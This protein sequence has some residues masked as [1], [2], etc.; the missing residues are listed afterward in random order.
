MSGKSDTFD[1]EHA[2]RQVLSGMTM[3]Q[4]NTA[5]SGIEALRLIE[6]ARDTAVKSRATTMITLKATL[7]TASD[8]LRTELENVTDFEF[9]AA[10]AQPP[11]ETSPTGPEATIRHVLGSSARRW[12]DLREE[13]KVRSRHLEKQT[14]AVAPRFVEAVGIG[15]DKAAER[16]S[17]T[18]TRPN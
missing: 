13:V 6:V 12:F 10:R 16:R 7:V 15:L 17:T 1:A 14:R 8:E 2:A 11:S 18:S 3:A 9:V 4:P 5:D